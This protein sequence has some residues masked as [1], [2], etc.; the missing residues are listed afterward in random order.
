MPLTI[1]DYAELKGCSKQAI[2]NA[3]KKHSDIAEHTYTGVA[4]GK[5]AQ[6]LDDVATALLDQRMRFPQKNTELITNELTR[7]VFEER[8]QLKADIVGQVSE[9]VQYQMQGVANKL[10]RVMLNAVESAQVE[11]L[12]EG[13]KSERERTNHEIKRYID[14]LAVLTKENTSLKVECKTKDLEIEKLKGDVGELRGTLA[15]LYQEIDKY[16]LI[17]NHQKEEIEWLHNHPYKNLFK[18]GGSN[19]KLTENN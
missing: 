10:E 1:A 11:T 4:N 6:Y 2:Y 17:I 3:I 13:I 12:K 9:N 18:K 15:G 5:S 16:R 7:Q 8:D 14:E 19:G